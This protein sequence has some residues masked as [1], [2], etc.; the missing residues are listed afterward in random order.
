MSGHSGIYLSQKIGTSK[1]FSEATETTL[2]HA[3]E[4]NPSMGGTIA[5]KIAAVFSQSATAEETK[6]S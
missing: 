6:S 2:R 1:T 4:R 3:R 5:A